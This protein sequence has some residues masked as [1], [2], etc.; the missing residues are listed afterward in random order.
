MLI[1]SWAWFAPSKRQLCYGHWL[2]P[3]RPFSPYI[4]HSNPRVPVPETIKAEEAKLTE[5]L[6]NGVWEVR[7]E[8][9]E[10]P[11]GW[12]GSGERT[13]DRQVPGQT[14]VLQSRKSERDRHH[15]IPVPRD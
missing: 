14:M 8:G 9:P 15:P 7:M 6:V 2:S 1:L 12:L 5:Y 3:L 4:G 11:H 13:G 10:W